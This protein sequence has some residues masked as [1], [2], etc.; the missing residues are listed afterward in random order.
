MPSDQNATKFSRRDAVWSG[1]SGLLMAVRARFS[2]ASSQAPSRLATYPNH[3]TPATHDAITK[4]VDWLASRQTADGGFGSPHSYARNVGVCALSGLAFLAHGKRGPLQSKIVGCTRYLLAQAQSSGLIVEDDVVTHAPLY[5]HGFAT[6]YLGQVYGED[7]R[8]EVRVALKRAVSLIISLQNEQGAWCYTSIPDDADVSVTTCQLM[9]LYSARQAGV[10]VPREI[11][12]RG[13]DFLRRCQN[14]DGGF[15]YRLIDPPESLF[16]RSAAAVATLHA[17]G[18]HDDEAVV[19]G[20]EYLANHSAIRSNSSPH[21]AEYYYYGRF[22]A[23]HAAWQAGGAAWDRWYPTVRDEFEQRQSSP[24]NWDDPNIGHEYAT[25]MALLV[26]Q[27]PY[28]GLP[29]F[30]L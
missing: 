26:L 5:G 22:Y 4:G 13:L 3:V 27:T 14:A 7:G 1:F 12:E 15:R 21:Q 17:A 16:P 9:A 8:P 20:R 2:H 24:G 30:L 11:I 23:T 28:A 18:L 6:L 10:A 19:R 25:A 29:M